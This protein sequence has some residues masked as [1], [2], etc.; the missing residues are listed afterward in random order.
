MSDCL[1]RSNLRSTRLLPRVQLKTP[2]RKL[3]FIIH[4][5]IFHKKFCT[6]IY[7]VVCILQY[8]YYNTLLIY[9]NDNNQNTKKRLLQV[10]THAVRPTSMCSTN[11]SLLKS[12][13][14]ANWWHRSYVGS[15]SIFADYCLIVCPKQIFKTLCVKSRRQQNARSDF[16]HCENMALATKPLLLSFEKILKIIVVAFSKVYRHLFVH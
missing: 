11:V 16:K 7:K 4:V 8:K 5:L 2:R 6:I 3:E 9:R 14:S 12:S 15:Y 1:K 10:A 13:V